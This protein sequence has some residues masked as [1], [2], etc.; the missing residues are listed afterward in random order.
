MVKII[1]FS[2]GINKGRKN[3]KPM[4]VL[5]YDD[6]KAEEY[7]LAYKVHQ[8]KKAPAVFAPIVCD[9][10]SEGSLSAQQLREMY[11][12]GHE[13]A[14]H[15]Y[16]HTSM[17]GFK[18]NFYHPNTNVEAGAEQLDLNNAVWFSQRTSRL[19]TKGII[20]EGGVEETFTATDRSNDV[21][22]LEAP[23]QNSYTTAAEVTHHPHTLIAEADAAKQKL[24]SY[25]INA[26]GYIYPAGG[27]GKA[28]RDIASRYFRWGRGVWHNGETNVF[29][30]LQGQDIFAMGSEEFAD[31]RGNELSNKEIERMMDEAVE[32]Q[33]MVCFHSHSFYPELTEKKIAWMIDTARAKGIEIVTFSEALNYYGA[34]NDIG[35]L[36]KPDYTDEFTITMYW[37][38][39]AFQVPVRGNNYNGK[40]PTVKSPNGTLWELVVD[41]A[42]NITTS[43]VKIE[44]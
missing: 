2:P 26:T 3:M 37:E 38:E 13:I 24:A 41:N 42:G 39:R 9:T 16:T 4:M 28:T 31:Y 1:N 19:N 40:K 25:G 23:L 10:D 32:R 44:I 29:D 17:E 14:I 5:S 15:S 11:N 7:T 18:G 34:P 8:E 43:K 21:L 36:D 35:Q 20:R 33:C 27:H 22:I 30:P 6:G 12:N